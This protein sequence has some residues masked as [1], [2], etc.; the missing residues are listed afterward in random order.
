MKINIPQSLS[1]E[2]LLFSSTDSQSFL[3]S[4]RWSALIHCPSSQANW[5]SAQIGDAWWMTEKK[6]I[7]INHQI[8][9][10]R[11]VHNYCILEEIRTEQE[12]SVNGICANSHLNH[13]HK[14]VNIWWS[15]LVFLLISIN[16]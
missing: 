11:L 1:S 4:Q 6:V 14:N 10:K 3:L 9:N 15:I 12:N 7:K 5:P 16:I 13:I 8:N 2:L